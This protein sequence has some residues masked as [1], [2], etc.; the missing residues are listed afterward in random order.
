M[1]LISAIGG[2]FAGALALTALH[3]TLRRINSKAPRMDKLGMQSIS[4]SLKA[5]DVSVPKKATLFKITMAGDVLANTFYYSL[6]GIGDKENMLVKGAVL[7]VAAGLGGV[8]LP[9]PMGLNPKPSART[10]ATK[11]MTIGLYLFGGVVASLTS[12]LIEEK[13]A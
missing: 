2:G 10:T 7:G 3:E 6:A 13:V 11:L 5:V 4:K 1:K 8:Y 9:K 12:Q